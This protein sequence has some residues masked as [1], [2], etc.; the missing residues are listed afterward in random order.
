[1]LAAAFVLAVTAPIRLPPVEKCS[2]DAQFS[3]TRQRLERVVAARDLDGLLALMS[4]DVRVSFGG[5]FGREGFRRHW[6]SA[7]KDRALLWKELDRALRLGC[8]KAVDGSGREYRAFPAMF[9]TGGDLDG[10]STWVSLPG[11]IL[12]SRPSAGAQ[13]VMRL[14]AWT[15]LDEAE[16]DG[17]SWIAARTPRGRRG[18]VS[19]AQARSLLDYRIIFGRRD[20]SWRITAFIAGD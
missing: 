6:I 13:A 9:V 15:V 5:R 8:A 11:A 7:P 20:G 4:D 18:F 12:R 19:T 3:R 10:F 16:H 14:P 2:G 17:G 1:M